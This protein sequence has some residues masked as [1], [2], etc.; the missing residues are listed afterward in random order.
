MRPGRRGSAI[1][2]MEMKGQAY[3]EEPKAAP[4][5]SKEK[6]GSSSCVLL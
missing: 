3:N 2:A 5:P 1:K 6:S 4:Q